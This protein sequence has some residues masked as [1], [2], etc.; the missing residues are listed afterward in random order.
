MKAKELKLKAWHTEQKRMFD[1]WGIGPDFITEDTLD[2]F[3]EGSNAFIG[4]DLNFIEVLRPTGL[5]DKND[6]MIYEG[7]ILLSESSSNTVIV[8]WG[9]RNVK[10]KGFPTYLDD[11]E[12]HGWVV[13]NV[14]T[15]MIGELD[16]SF[17]SGS[18]IGNIYSNPELL[19]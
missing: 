10:I 8:K 11:F 16:I 15:G 7:D 17:Y 5:K 9:V 6:K 3:E 12:M 2:G 4:E 14:K 1:V 19:K 13:K 18:I